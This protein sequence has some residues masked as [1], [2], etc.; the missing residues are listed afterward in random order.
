MK[1][2]N[3]GTR[4]EIRSTPW[5]TW[6]TRPVSPRI[7]LRPIL[8]SGLTVCVRSKETADLS[9]PLR[10]GPTARRGRRDDKFIAG[11]LL[12]CQSE[13]GRLLLN[14]FVI[15]PARRAVGPERTRISCHA[16][17]DKAACAPFFKER[18]MMFANATN[19]YRK[20]GVAQWRD[21]R[22]PLSSATL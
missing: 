6:G 10:S 14:R 8:F 7:L 2:A 4:Q 17:L 18:R 3:A 22:F 12:Y 13:N 11:R 5:R 16:G 21:L 1:F 15:S 20:S 9:T 19:F